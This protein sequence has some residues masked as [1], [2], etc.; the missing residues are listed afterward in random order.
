MRAATAD[1]LLRCLLPDERAAVEG[2]LAELHVPARDALIELLGLV[3][4]RQVGAWTDWHA[5][6]ALVAALALGIILSVV[7]RYWAH[8]AAIYAWLYLDNWTPEYLRSPGARADL[9]RTITGFGLE[10]LTLAVWAWTIGSAIRA[11]SPRTW[12]STFIVVVIAVFYGTAGSA[13]IARLNPGNAI[14]FAQ[15]MYRDGFPM[16]FRL[17]LIVAPILGALW[18]ANIRSSVKVGRAGLIL[19]AAVVLTALVGRRPAAAATFGWWSISDDRPMLAAAWRIR[20]AWQV[21]LFPLVMVCP[22]IY[23]FFNSASR[24]GRRRLSVR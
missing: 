21:W 10:C 15:P 8:N 22:A 24:S 6:I 13:T 12:F 5:W 2:D 4:R 11:L 20:Q 1:R 18:H 16:A 9:L 19:C 14:V 3:V 23:V 7:S 17:V